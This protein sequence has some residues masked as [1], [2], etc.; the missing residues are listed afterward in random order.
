VHRLMQ[1]PGLCSLFR[2]KKVIPPV[3]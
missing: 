1:R 3:L 2:K